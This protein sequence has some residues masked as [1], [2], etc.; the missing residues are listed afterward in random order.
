MT[1][2]SI[3]ILSSVH[4]TYDVRMFQAE[5]RSLARA[6]FQVYLIALEDSTQSETDGVEI[7]PIPRPRNRLER[8]LR[9]FVVL[10]L[11]L[12][13]P[14][15]LYAFHDPE[16]IPVAVLLKALTRRKIVYDVHEDV[17][18]QVYAKEWIARPL[19]PL[20]S[21]LYRLFER[22][23]LPFIDGLTL[24]DH[25]YEK[26]YRGRNTLAVL[27]YPL[28]TYAHLYEEKPSAPNP[29]PTLIYAG[30][31]RQIRGLFTMVDLVRRLRPSYPDILLKLVG[32]IATQEEEERLEGLVRDND[33]A[34]NIECTGLVS[35]QEVHRLMRDADLGFCPALSRS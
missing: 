11:A 3:C 32:P 2:N 5:A 16:L 17:P 22:C 18:A 19:R 31:I 4:F 7:I 25:A 10:R 14:V 8:M 21:R 33:L 9:T 12:R 6:G 23:T 26:Y 28:L 34:E 15:A 29:R 27:N 20:V 24:A 30:S 13:Q 1:A 35:H